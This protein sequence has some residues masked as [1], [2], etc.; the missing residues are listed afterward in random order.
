MPERVQVERVQVL[1][2]SRFE[3]RDARF[4]HIAAG[5]AWL[6]LALAAVLLGA[7]WMYPG[8]MTDQY[9]AGPLPNFA[10]PKLQASPRAD[11]DRFRS[12]QLGALNGVYWLDRAH[13]VVHLPIA[14]AMRKVAEE[15]I[16]DWPA[17]K[18]ARR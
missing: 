13:G 11:M 3:G 14:D 12:Q 6:A 5:A 4:R 10:Q 2:P 18:Q 1:A 17:P 8:T 9:V 7:L 16:A 15:G